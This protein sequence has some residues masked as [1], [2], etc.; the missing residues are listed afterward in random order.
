MVS[1]NGRGTSFSPGDC[2]PPKCHPER[3]RQ[4]CAKDL[5]LATATKLGSSMR[6]SLSLEFYVEVN[7]N[8]GATYA[9]EPGAQF[10][11]TVLD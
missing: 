9:T 1:N 3:I 11:D 2:R 10:S 4:G 5:N 8:G 6:L 7:R